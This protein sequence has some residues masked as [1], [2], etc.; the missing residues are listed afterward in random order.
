[1]R[2]DHPESAPGAVREP[3]PGSRRSFIRT[4]SITV[5]AAALGA[6]GASALAVPSAAAAPMTAVEAARRAGRPIALTPA[7]DG[8]ETPAA[9]EGPLFKPETP[10]RTDL[11]TPGIKGVEVVM[12]GTVYDAAC[13]PLPGTLIDFWQCDQNGDYDTAGFSLRGHQYTTARGTYR[14]RTIIPRDYAGRWGT[15]APH[16][17][18]MVQ[19]PGGP[20]LITQLYF[21]DDTRAY[22]RDFAALNAADTIINRACTIALTGP[23]DGVYAGAFDF[24]IKTTAP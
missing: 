23:T 3:R 1:M 2:D 10:E 4:G 5:T 6:A 17:H 11:I 22:G 24:V 18:T 13:R 7:C 14:L 21:P 19:T 20:V 8:H 15:R 16:I 12:T 9:M